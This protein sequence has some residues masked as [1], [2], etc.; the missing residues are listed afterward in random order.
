MSES[1]LHYI[2][3]CQYFNKLALTTT[4]GVALQVLSPGAV[5][6]HAGP[7]FSNARVRIGDVEWVGNV[8]IHIESS[9]WFEHTHHCDAA[10]NTTILHVVW[11]NDKPA[12]RNDGSLIPTLELQKRVDVR[13]QEKY[14]SLTHNFNVI[15]C[16]ESIG[17]VS[18]LTLFSALDKALTIRLERKART[19]LDMYTRNHHDWEETCYQLLARNF[20]FKIN[21]DPFQQLALSL[22]YKIIRKH[23]DKIESIEALLLGQAGFLKETCEDVHIQVLQREHALLSQKFGLGQKQLHKSQWKFMRLRPANFPTIRLAQFAALLE[24][25]SL[26]SRILEADSMT[27]LRSIFQVQQSAYWQQHYKPGKIAQ[28][29]IAGL[30]EGSVDMLIINAVAPLLVAYGLQ[31]DQDLY[32]AR[33]V[34][35]LQQIPPESNYIM[36]QWSAIRIKAQ[37]AFD[38]QA[39]IELYANFCSDNR[40]LDC[41][42]GAAL[43]KPD[44]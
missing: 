4:D 40:C 8:E 5:N 3:Q 31:H 35:I 19:V 12:V 11:H 13:L 6:T 38:S 32:T 10:Y 29:K 9:E 43:V 37:N 17:Q 26:M 30:G 24:Q 18:D 33:A 21:A 7:D 2:W 23:G 14:H 22:P 42:I 27:V 44:T 34:E 15:P 20:G 39:L 36:R 25:H 1:F 41:N 16:Q 28:E